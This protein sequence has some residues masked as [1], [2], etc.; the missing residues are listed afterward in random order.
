MPANKLPENPLEVL[1]RLEKRVRIME[2]SR[3]LP[4]FIGAQV[5]KT[6]NQ[7][8]A[9]GMSTVELITFGTPDFDT[10]SF[11]NATN[12]TLVC[13]D[14]LAGY[15]WIY[16]KVEW[17]N[18]TGPL[19]TRLRLNSTGFTENYSG[20]A[21]SPVDTSVPIGITKYL[22]EGDF[23]ELVASQNQGSDRQ[24][25]GSGDDYGTYLGMYF[26]GR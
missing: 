21:G 14:D 20:S 7:T 1:K 4:S 25:I 6:A 11:F 13:P 17:E 18:G 23:I 3:R 16:A 15:Y 19:R 9:T 26:L 2:Q 12:D 22:N 24:V 8:I 10:D 5:T